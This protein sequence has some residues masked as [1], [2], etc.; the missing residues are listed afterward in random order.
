MLQPDGLW[1]SIDMAIHCWALAIKFHTLS[2]RQDPGVC[3]FHVLS[4]YLF[5]LSLIMSDQLYFDL[6]GIAAAKF[7]E[8]ITRTSATFPTAMHKARIM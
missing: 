1:Q 4:D 3:K 5:L 2:V 8:P 6:T 7:T